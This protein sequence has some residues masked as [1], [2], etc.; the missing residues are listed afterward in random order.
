[1]FMKGILHPLIF[2]TFCLI[3]SASVNGQKLT[4][5]KLQTFL[6]KASKKTAEYSATF[7]NLTVE[8]TKNFETFDENGRVKNSRKILS[9]LIIYEAEN[10]KGNLAEYRN[11]REVNGKKIK[12]SEIRTV[13]V[14]AQLADAKSFADELKKLNEEGS[15]YDK[16][17]SFNG[18][19]LF[20]AVPLH[21]NPASFKFDE[22][23]REIIEGNEAVA[24]KFQQTAVDP[25]INLSVVVP[26]I[27]EATNKFYR[28]IAWLD[29]KNHRILR[30]LTEVTFESPKF[31]EPFVVI[32]QEYFY[33]PGDFEI[34]LPRK[35]VSENFNPK[36]EKSAKLLLKTGKIKPVSQLQTRLTMEY[37]NF[38]KFD[39]TVKA[40]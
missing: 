2:F 12:D 20:Q 32:K 17:L 29:L 38:S 3:L 37:K 4:G 34:Y 39:V 31:T 19:I 25:N 33:Q 6:A 15:R 24:V 13:K 27:L 1:M 40:N 8:E 10:D 18:L 9:D 35:I 26:D 7:K 28:G 11:V 14:F 16:G 5:S 21:F 36:I 22:I 30:L 23:G